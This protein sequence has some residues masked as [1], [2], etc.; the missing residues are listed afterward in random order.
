MTCPLCHSTKAATE[1]ANREANPGFS[2]NAISTLGW[3]R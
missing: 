2:N 1:V 3:V